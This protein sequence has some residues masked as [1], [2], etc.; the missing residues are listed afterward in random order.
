MSMA[1]LQLFAIRKRG[2]QREKALENYLAK[3]AGPNWQ[4]SSMRRDR[5]PGMTPSSQD[6][7]DMAP[8]PTLTA[9]GGFMSPS[10][11][12]SNSVPRMQS[13]PEGDSATD[14]ESQKAFVEQ[15]RLLVL[16]MEQRLQ[17]RE[18]KLLRTMEK[19]EAEGARFE[20]LRKQMA[21]TS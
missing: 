11:A 16:G 13:A 21:T 15:V 2:K 5:V 17:N 18:E 1:Q 6:N 8:L 4:V 7:L 12:R 19:A 9:R 10:H 3:L 14:A 20:E